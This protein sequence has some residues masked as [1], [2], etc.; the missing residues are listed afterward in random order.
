MVFSR[1]IWTVIGMVLA[2]VATSL[3]LGIMVQK[4]GYPFTWSILVI[5][6]VLE[7]ALLVYFL[8]R[9]RRDLLRLVLALRNEDPTLQFSR[10]QRDP[11]FSAIHRGFNEIIRDFRLVRLDR[12]AEHQFFEATVNHIQ[13]GI[14]AFDEEGKTALVND[15]FLKQ[16]AVEKLP[17]IDSLEAA[18]PGL[19]DW[20]KQIAGEAEQ[21]KKVHLRGEPCH[22]IFLASRFSLRGR[23]I[24]LVSVRDISREIDRNELE[25]WQK[26]MRVL[27]HEILNSL[28]PIR[29][30][31][32]NLAGTLSGLSGKDPLPQGLEDLRTGLE[33]I[34]RRAAGLSEFLDI[35]SNLYRVPELE[36]RKTG[37][38]ELLERIRQ[39]FGEQFETEGIDCVLECRDDALMIP[40]DERMVEQVLINL[41][42]N[43][44]EALRGRKAAVLSLSAWQTKE[45]ACLS[46][47][48]NGKGIQE[49]QLEHIFIPFY[50]TREEGSGVGLSFAQHIM[51]LHR[52]RI[53]VQSTPGKGSEFQLLF[54]KDCSK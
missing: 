13:F 45:E 4:P 20:M 1:F 23:V 50:S 25:A 35:Y 9:I 34:H 38:R 29:L 24:T 46:V 17:T 37:A 5:L 7:T 48:D 10:T 41:V 31:A 33:T 39:L 52:G 14:V 30:L 18:V 44:V 42:R 19:P 28:T 12:E 22:L 32:G 16:F 54:R 21:L 15:A 36:I 53:R 43:A 2:L 3:A 27:R 11:Y 8:L 51:R 47:S 49:D 6:L 26:L 40:M